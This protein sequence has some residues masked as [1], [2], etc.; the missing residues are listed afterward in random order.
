MSDIEFVNGLMAKAPHPNAPDFVKGALSINREGLIAW[1]TARDDEWINADIKES[2]AGKW[3][4]AVNDY[5]PA[6][7]PQPAANDAP[8]ADEGGMPF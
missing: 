1:L 2:R 6:N 5:K 4:V 3:Y 8:P 7:D